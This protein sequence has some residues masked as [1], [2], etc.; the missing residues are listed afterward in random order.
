MSTF[1]F[2][3]WKL[4]GLLSSDDL[5][6]CRRCQNLAKQH[7]RH[8]ARVRWM[9]YGSDVALKVVVLV[10]HLCEESGKGLVLALKL[11]QLVTNNTM[12]ARASESKRCRVC[13]CRGVGGAAHL[14]QRE[15]SR[16][17][18]LS[19]CCLKASTSPVMASTMASL[20]MSSACST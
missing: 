3:K 20:E 15:K 14:M 13:R 12:L 5:S 9:T 17:T 1:I 11:S 10:L 16:L 6:S 18:S 19:L 8:R 4:I 2:G 7:G